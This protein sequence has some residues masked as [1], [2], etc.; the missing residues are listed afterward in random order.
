M[1]IRSRHKNAPPTYHLIY[2][3]WLGLKEHGGV[4]LS[5]TFLSL[6][7]GISIS[8]SLIKSFATKRMSAPQLCVGVL[9]RSSVSSGHFPLLP[10]CLWNAFH[11]TLSYLTAAGSGQKTVEQT[12]C[13]LVVEE[14]FW[15]FSFTLI[16][17]D[18]FRR[19]EM[20]NNKMS[21]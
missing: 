6:F 13:R 7:S 11:A 12:T 16:I 9:M 21:K 19:I 17:L 3:K 2:F 20:K 8:D 4:Q 15:I 1:V 5:N 14:I 18:A 10:F